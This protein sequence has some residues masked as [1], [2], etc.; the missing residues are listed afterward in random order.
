MFVL[1]VLVR[2]VFLWFG[3]EVPNVNLT[4]AALEKDVAK[5]TTEYSDNERNDTVFDEAEDDDDDDYFQQFT[6]GET[7]TASAKPNLDIPTDSSLSSSAGGD[8]R[9]PFENLR[10]VFMGDSL[11]RYQYLS[12]AYRLR[13]RR[14]FDPNITVNNLVSAHS[15]HHPLHPKED[16]NEFF[17]QSNRIL[18]PMEI[19]DC[20]RSHDGSVVLERRYF[21][22][23]EHNNMLVYI[24]MNGKETSPGHGYY[25]RLDPA[26]IFGPMFSDVESLPFGMQSDGGYN[27]SN[28]EWDFSTW[29]DVIRFHVGYLDFAYNSEESKI[30]KKVYVLL[31]AGLHPHDFRNI[32]VASDIQSAL[33]E[34]S[35]HGIWKTTTY[36]IQDLLEFQ[37]QLKFSYQ[38]QRQPY[39]RNTDREMCRMLGS[40]FNI[41][42]TSLLKHE[43]YLD[44]LHF[45]EPVYRIMN[46]DYLDQLGLV[47]HG[48]KKANR[49]RILVEGANHWLT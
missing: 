4:A 12:L 34:T 42:W 7:T 1:F 41:S 47:P 2:L 40:C 16:W 31:N 35:L 9:T 43:L 33:L 36:P 15:F 26:N 45:L 10:L 8:G 28:I 32:S 25:G 30:D 23:E 11:T 5:I 22:D 20:L 6:A 13:Y 18:H 48:Y 37:A 39:T 24:N 29:A 14:W 3:R 49:S 19:C 46:E 17:L 44:D 27:E 21:Y 38:P